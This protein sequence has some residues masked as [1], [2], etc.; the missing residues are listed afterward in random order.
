MTD[1]RA[2]GSV[3]FASARLAGLAVVQKEAAIGGV[4]KMDLSNGFGR[5]M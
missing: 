1:A 5:G 4:E 3:H 2:D